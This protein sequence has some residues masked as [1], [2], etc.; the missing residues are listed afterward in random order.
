MIAGLRRLSLLKRARPHDAGDR[1]NL[2]HHDSRSKIGAYSLVCFSGS[3]NVACVCTPELR[4]YTRSPELEALPHFGSQI[5]SPKSASCFEVVAL[6]MEKN[7]RTKMNRF[8]EIKRIGILF[9]ATVGAALLALP[10]HAQ[11]R[12][13]A[14]VGSGSRSGYHNGPGRRTGFIRSR[15]DGFFNGSSF[16][17]YG[18]SDSDFDQFDDQD[19]SDE[20]DAPPATPVQVFIEPPA[21]PPVPPPPPAD[22]L[23]V[24]YHDG[25]YVRIPTGSDLPRLAKSI[26]ET[27]SQ[28]PGIRPGME[29]HKDA[30]LPPHAL[31]HVILLFRD[32]HKEEIGKYVIQNDV[33]YAG[34]DYWKTGS[35]TKVIP[36]AQLDVP[37]TLELNQLRGTKFSL[38]S[39]P[40]EITVRF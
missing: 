37:A 25:Q 33:I 5:Q 8:E 32:G 24:E 12:G 13:A 39:G 22:S 26:P 19:S 9:I 28:T 16:L 20:P 17:P 29:S 31:P 15:R 18:C 2:S 21:P 38:P 30:A 40:A 23:L 3:G 14:G 35:W 7:G 36:I 34:A 4:T 6:A 1:Q 27:S 10:S 11:G